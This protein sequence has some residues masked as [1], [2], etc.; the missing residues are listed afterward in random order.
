MPKQIEV[1]SASIHDIHKRHVTLRSTK[2]DE[3]LQ[4]A[5]EKSMCIMLVITEKAL[6][7]SIWFRDCKPSAL[8]QQLMAS[9]HN[10]LALCLD[11]ESYS[12]D[13]FPA[14]NSVEEFDGSVLVP[15]EA[16][17]KH[18]K[19]LCGDTD[20]DLRKLDVEADLRTD[21]SINALCEEAT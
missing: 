8:L 4:S 15:W 12:D 19:I 5:V 3:C 21:I 17:I 1:A 6:N 9:R 16:L 11:T 7:K 14:G 13:L 20:E 10:V 2:I 18:I